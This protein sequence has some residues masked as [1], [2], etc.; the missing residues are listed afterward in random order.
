MLSRDKTNLFP[1][2]VSVVLFG[3][4][5]VSLLVCASCEREGLLL[6]I[7]AKIS[8]KAQRSGMD[9]RAPADSGNAQNKTTPILWN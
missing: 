2:P 9:S 1:D 3:I 4:G 6:T 5:A 8:H 7:N